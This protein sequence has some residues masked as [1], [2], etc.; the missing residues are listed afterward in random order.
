LDENLGMG[1]IAPDI[2][3]TAADLLFILE[4][5]DWKWDIN[6]ILAQPSDLFYAVLQL[7]GVAEKIKKNNKS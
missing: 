1:G 6:T 4:A 2:L 7:K 5:L 3:H